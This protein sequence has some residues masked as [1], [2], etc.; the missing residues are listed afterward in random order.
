MKKTINVKV[1]KEPSEM[2]SIFNENTESYHI[3]KDYEISIPSGDT[4]SINKWVDDRDNSF[5]S[6]WDFLTP[7]D[8]KEYEKMSEEEQDTFYDFVMDLKL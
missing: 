2:F 7:E 1:I 5:E 4:I 6:D 3:S 8:K